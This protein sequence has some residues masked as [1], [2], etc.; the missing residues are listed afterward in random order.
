MT[1][2][3]DHPAVDQPAIDSEA[4]ERVGPADAGAGDATPL[5]E[6]AANRRF[7]LSS[8]IAELM[9]LC[10]VVAVP[11][12]MIFRP[13]GA[14]LRIPI[15]YGGDAFV[16]AMYV[17]NMSNGWSWNTTDLLGAPYGQHTQDFPAGADRFHLVVMKLISLAG[18]SPLTTVNVYYLLGFF[19]AAIAAHLAMRALGLRPLAAGFVAVLFAFLPYHFA[20]GPGHPFLSAYHAVPLGLVF[21]VCVARGALTPPLARLAS[22]PSGRR[23]L[24][25]CAA[26]TILVVGTSSPY[27]AIFTC[28]LVGWVAVFRAV[29]SWSWRPLLAGAMVGGAVMIVMAGSLYPELAW[30]ADKGE[31]TLVAQRS[32]AE[33]EAYGLHL[34]QALLPSPSHRVVAFA[35]LGR[36]ALEAPAPGELGTSIGVVAALGLV[37]LV[38]LGLRGRSAL[39][40]SADLSADLRHSAL[41]ILAG[42]FLLATVGGLGMVIALGGFTEIRAWG[43]M[44]V[45]IGL[46]GLA[47]FA[48]VL[49]NLVSR[50]AGKWRS[51]V[52]AVVLGGAL[53]VGLLD[54]VP[55]NA[56]PA[57]AANEA[58]RDVDL[59]FIAQMG[60]E[61]DAGSSVFQMPVVTFP[62][63]GP[64]FA[65]PDY[66]EMIGY[67]LDDRGLRWSYGGVK[68]RESVW[69]R[70]WMTQPVPLRLAGLATAGF[71][72]LYIDRTGFADGGATLE[73]TARAMLQTPRGASADGRLVWY[74]LRPL[75]A[76]L[77][78][79]E[80]FAP[81]T[82][83]AA[84]T[85][86]LL[87]LP[88]A[89]VYGPEG[90][91]RWF[92]RS[93]RFEIVDESGSSADVRLRGR[94]VGPSGSTVTLRAGG[95]DAV[96]DLAPDGAPI[97]ITVP[98]VDGRAEVEF[99]TTAP[100]VVAPGDPRTMHFQTVDLVVQ[101]A[102][103]DGVIRSLAG[104]L[105]SLFPNL[106]GSR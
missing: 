56:R 19:L 17:K 27:Y 106:E 6:T 34:A 31:N 72:A 45:L 87:M 29:V 63:N 52:R 35:Q 33:S 101:D 9:A 36:D 60:D 104:A 39:A 59:A 80:G 8:L 10:A 5:G 38:A 67:L 78:A 68:G 28:L 84:V 86:P 41:V 53:V 75:A 58:R 65:M 95:R 4:F 105:S 25:A 82:V 14:R 32:P 74:D 37:A 97:D 49:E 30:R 77:R 40:W 88:H 93:G 11:V 89:G 2:P 12:A 57:Y 50:L 23:A 13:W 46:V 42:A 73:A 20:H 99:V 54:Q 15:V 64:A 91:A 92:S 102:S 70:T 76:Q 22:K 81:A 61:L 47:G 83:A 100:Q 79:L 96:V 62:E 16:H 7:G 3:I 44:A 43:R 1:A 71:D 55:G 90:P 66:A 69:Q 94:V 18:A 103:A 98:L 48:L 51:I 24:Y 26:V 21:V 85:R